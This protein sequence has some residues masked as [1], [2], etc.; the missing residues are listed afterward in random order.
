MAGWAGTIRTNPNYKARN[1]G[2]ASMAT[3]SF[4]RIYSLNDTPDIFTKRYWMR[5]KK[6]AIDNQECENEIALNRK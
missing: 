2:T 4:I 3:P 6:N 1:R 5:F